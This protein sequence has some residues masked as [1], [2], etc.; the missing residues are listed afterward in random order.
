MLVFDG[1]V[2]YCDDCSE[3]DSG[4]RVYKSPCIICGETVIN[5]GRNRKSLH[6]QC[7]IDDIYD[8]LYAGERLTQIQYQRASNYGIST[9]EIKREVAEDK[10][11]RI[12]D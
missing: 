12:K 11:G 10:E 5:S 2:K 8:T 1:R 9:L 6:R 4:E 3:T 7:I